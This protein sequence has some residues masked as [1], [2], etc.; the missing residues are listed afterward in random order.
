M[1][2]N[3]SKIKYKTNLKNKYDQNWIYYQFF[4]N[5]KSFFSTPFG[6]CWSFLGIDNI[7]YGISFKISKSV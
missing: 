3:N 6:N 7:E 1:S 2:I 5:K 4:E